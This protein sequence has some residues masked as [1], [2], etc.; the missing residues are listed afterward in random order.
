MENS[1]E[2]ITEKYIENL[3]TQIE[4]LKK[5]IQTMKDTWYTPAEFLK[6]EMEAKLAVAEI[7][8]IMLRK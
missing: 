2:K 7:E 5:E 3:E 8:K 1:K 4:D 6:L